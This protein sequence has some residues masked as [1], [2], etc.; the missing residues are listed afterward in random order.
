MWTASSTESLG[1]NHGHRIT[2]SCREVKSHHWW[3]HQILPGGM[4]SIPNF[5]AGS[6]PRGASDPKSCKRACSP[7]AQRKLVPPI[8]FPLALLVWRLACQHLHQ[9]APNSRHFPM[10]FFPFGVLA[11]YKM[12]AFHGPRG[13]SPHEPRQ[14]KASWFP[15]FGL[16]LQRRP[17]HWWGEKAMHY[18]EGVHLRLRKELQRHP[19]NS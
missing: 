9:A 19:K 10:V 4:E 13:H 11:S 2:S 7:K 3:V 18:D 5:S 17:L 12:L 16:R 6:S 15:R 14:V 1:Q 8:I